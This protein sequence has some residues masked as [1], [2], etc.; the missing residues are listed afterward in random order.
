MSRPCSSATCCM[1]EEGKKG[2]VGVEGL[3]VGERMPDF[4]HSQQWEGTV[5]G[6]KVHQRLGTGL[7][8]HNQRQD[9]Y[10]EKTRLILTNF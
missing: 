2:K 3:A 4:L 9:G 8:P 6:V 1:G 7:S 5:R 10:G